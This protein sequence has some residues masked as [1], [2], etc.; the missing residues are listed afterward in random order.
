M[1]Q[2]C[3]IS[4]FSWYFRHS[5]FNPFF[6]SSPHASICALWSCWTCCALALSQE[7]SPEVTLCVCACCRMEQFQ[8]NQWRRM[9]TPGEVT[10]AT[11]LSLSSPVWATQWAW[12]TSGGFPISATE[13]E[14]VRIRDGTL[15]TLSPSLINA[16]SSCRERG[17][18]VASAALQQQQRCA[19]TCFHMN[20]IPIDDNTAQQNLTPAKVL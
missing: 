12:A 4:L 7:C 3:I 20:H 9:K 8:E 16:S 15:V 1:W 13:M 2:G 17:G 14:E 6:F 5:S 19:Q 10:G 18:C 11:R